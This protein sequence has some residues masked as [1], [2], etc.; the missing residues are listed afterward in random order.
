MDLS[1]DLDIVQQ[2]ALSA[3][4]ID[5]IIDF[6]LTSSSINDKLKSKHIIN[7]LKTKFDITKSMIDNMVCDGGNCV[8]P[9]E[10]LLR[11]NSK[12]N[13][14][15]YARVGE[16]S[17]YPTLATLVRNALRDNRYVDKYWNDIKTED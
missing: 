3:D 10:D 12:I 1:Y 9:W 16:G 5:D 2:I 13:A 17:D 4:S 14:T 8:S 15:K 7:L 11:E 6:S